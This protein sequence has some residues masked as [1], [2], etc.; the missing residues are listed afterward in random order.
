VTID[1]EQEVD[2]Y[3]VNSI[4]WEF[5]VDDRELKH[6][7]L[8]DPDLGDR[9]IL[10]MWVADMDFLAAPPIVEAV[11]RRAQRG[12]Y[13]Y[14]SKTDSYLSAVCGWMARHKAWAVN[15][16]WILMMPGVVTA[17]HVIVRHFTAPGDKVLIQRPVYHPFTFSIENNQ[18][19]VASSALRLTGDRYEMD[20]DD[21]AE[22]A[23]DPAAKLAI[24]CSPH[25]PVGRVW[26]REE[27]T[28]Y[29]EICSENGVRVIA[30]ELHSDLIMPGGQFVSYG[31]L[32]E[33]F[34]KDV[35]V[36]TAP[37][38]TF[39]LAGLQTSNIIVPDAE[40]RDELRIELRALGLW[41]TNPFGL[42][43]TEAAYNHGEPWL[44]QVIDYIWGNLEYLDNYLKSRLS[45]MKLIPIEGTYLAWIDCRGLGLDGAALNRLMMDDARVYVDGGHIF[46]PE[47]E[48][49]VRINVACRRQTLEQAL[50]RIERAVNDQIGG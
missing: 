15:P 43:G 28:R 6:W 12:L 37:S 9:S 41:G 23:A 36:C 22:K 17:L 16:E 44:E 25:N 47:G 27:L 31:T 1:F 14:A 30:D 46:G 49:F 24:L 39:S 11:T 45:S 34:L 38:K 29:A 19:E 5:M 48:G 40:L 50:A 35:F 2:H 7:D 21:L 18:R 8:T 13:G 32:D 20:F 33:R 10:P 42:V 26:S 4:K 3:G